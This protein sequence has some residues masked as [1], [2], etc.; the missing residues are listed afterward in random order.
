MHE[1]LMDKQDAFSDKTQKQMKELT[2]KIADEIGLDV[3]QFRSDFG[4]DSYEKIINGDRKL[5]KKLGVSGTPT[6]LING[7]FVNG[8]ISYD[9]FKSIVQ[10]HLIQARNLLNQGVD[11]ANIYPYAVNKNIESQSTSSE[12]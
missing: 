1:A 10:E 12:E 6:F 3:S 5:G 4:K 9:R 7:T 11:P 8:N 2:T